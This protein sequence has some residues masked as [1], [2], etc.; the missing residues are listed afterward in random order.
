MFLYSKIQCPLSAKNGKFI[1]KKGKKVNAI[2]TVGLS[3]N[4]A[5]S[6]EII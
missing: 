6:Y 5:I 4:I 1:R 3:C 2:A